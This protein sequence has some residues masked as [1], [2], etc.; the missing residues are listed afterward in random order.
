MAIEN[1]GG[2]LTYCPKACYGFAVGAILPLPNERALSHRSIK[3]LNHG[4]VNHVLSGNWKDHRECHIMP[5]LLL[6]YQ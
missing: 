6:I 5:D 3:R 4:H 2:I 1:I